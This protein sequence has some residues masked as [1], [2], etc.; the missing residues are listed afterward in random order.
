M[1]NSEDDALRKVLLPSG[2]GT[3]SDDHL[4]ILLD[5]YKLFVETSEKLVAR[6]QTLNTF[7]SINQYTGSFVGW[8]NR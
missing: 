6:R 2:A 5:Q 8:S 1:S 4:K 3:I 7:F